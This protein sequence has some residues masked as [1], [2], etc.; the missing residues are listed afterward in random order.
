[1]DY[2]EKI[3]L[4]AKSTFN[5]GLTSAGN[6]QMLDLFGHPVKGAAYLKSGDCTSPNNKSFV[7][8]L[9]TRSVGPFKVTGLKP[10]LDALTEI[11]ARVKAE[12]P[13]LYDMLG[14]AG[15]Q[16]SR[17]TKIRQKDGTLKIGPNISNHSWGTAVDIKLKGQLDK[18]G[19]NDTLRGLLVLSAYFNA[20]NWYWGAGFSTE[21]AMHF[22][23]SKSL[24]AKWKAAGTI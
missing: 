14:T 18:Q 8:L 6:Q 19:D 5:V 21:D 17:F 9:E 4:P 16:C 12:L 15:M 20:A 13:D 7:A 2:L 23:V 3:P 11:L 22:E 1:M 10:A 24:L